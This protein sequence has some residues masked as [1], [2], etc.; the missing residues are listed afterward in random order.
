MPSVLL[1]KARAYE[2]EHLPQVLPSILPRFHVSGIVGWINDPNGFSLYRGEY[3]LFFQYNPYSIHWDTMH[4]GHVK[5]RDFIK[6]ERLPCALAPDKEY[7]SMGCFS[8]SAIELRDGRHLLMYTGVAETEDQCVLQTQC[9][10][11][12]DGI[13]Y[14]KFDGNP[15]IT[16]DSLP[17]GGSREH[18]R[19]PKIWES[20]DGF[21]AVAGNLDSDGNGEVL[22][23]Q[24]DDAV[25]WRFVSKVASSD[26]RLGRMWECPDLFR[27]DDK[28]VLIVSP[29][30]MNTGGMEFIVGNTTL[31]LIGELSPDGQMIRESEHTIDYGLDFYAPQTLLTADGRRV[32]IAWMQYWDSVNIC[33]AD[34]PFFGQMTLP[35]ELS[36]R[37]GRLIQNPVRELGAYHGD[38]VAHTGV[39]INGRTQLTGIRG[40]SLDMTV[41]VHP[42]GGEIFRSFTV[43][44][45]QGGDYVTTILY[46]PETNTVIV[47]RNRSGWPEK[48]LNQRAFE[49]RE[50][51]GEITLRV[52][53]DRYSME[54]FVNDGEQ[55]ASYLIF[56][57]EEADSISFEADGDAVIDVE[58]FSIE[59]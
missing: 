16:A 22:L 44:L 32:M 30:E 19:D 41:R 37:D 4:W 45:A 35:R 29:Q 20:E 33:P 27:L 1:S 9:L 58:K 18:F 15:V 6:W 43:F 39:L 52:V 38:R 31:C 36:V 12:G 56:S 5:T 48:V 51:A 17:P 53:L 25:H 34:L 2:A 49:V 13:N 47:D 7:D 14:E 3:H 42:A 23:F 24:S 55:A 57:P 46:H 21:R 26:N 40:R 10:A 59:I 8:G 50:C 54:L 11:F 28:D